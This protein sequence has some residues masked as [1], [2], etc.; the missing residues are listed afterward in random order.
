MKEDISIWRLQCKYSRLPTCRKL[1]IQL[2]LALA[3]GPRPTWR[4]GK[5]TGQKLDLRVM[6]GGDCLKRE[7]KIFSEAVGAHQ[8]LVR[9]PNQAHSSGQTRSNQFT[10]YKLISYELMLPTQ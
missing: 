3:A 1:G 6:Q 2:G 10:L 5:L 4:P 9:V 7:L 8:S